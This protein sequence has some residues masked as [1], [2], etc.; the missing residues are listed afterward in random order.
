MIGQQNAQFDYGAFMGEIEVL[1]AR[2]DAFTQQDRKFDSPALKN[3]R[4][5]LHDFIQRIESDGYRINCDDASRVY[6]VRSYGSISNRDQQQAFDNAFAATLGELEHLVSTYAKYGDPKPT[7]RPGGARPIAAPVPA[8]AAPAKLEIPERITIPWVLKNISLLHALTAVAGI[9]AIFSAGLFF[10]GTK[11][12]QTV[13]AWFTP[14]ATS[15]A[16]SPDGSGNRFT[17][18]QKGPQQQADPQ[19]QTA[20][21]R[22]KDDATSNLGAIMQ[23]MGKSQGE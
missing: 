12:G 2:A 4:H 13:V 5:Q 22:T 17:Q 6:Y 14:T 23:N 16:S 1:L 10:G 8:E 9:M 7:A 21:R 19:S 3:W 18:P 20:A 15:P 11:A